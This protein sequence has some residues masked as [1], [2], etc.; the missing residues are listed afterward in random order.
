[1]R[2]TPKRTTPLGELVAAAF[3]GARLFSTDPAEVARLA[4]QA[5]EMAVRR[6]RA[7][8]LGA[9]EVGAAAP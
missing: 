8:E 4:T 2:R 5:V 1:M 3:D 6:G 7:L 9:A